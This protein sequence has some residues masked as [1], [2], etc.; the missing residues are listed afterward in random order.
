MFALTL[1]CSWCLWCLCLLLCLG[2][3]LPYH[4]LGL[5]KLVAQEPTLL[6]SLAFVIASVTP[7]SISALFC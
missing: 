7:F 4:V 5:W 1:W 6:D 2:H 3:A